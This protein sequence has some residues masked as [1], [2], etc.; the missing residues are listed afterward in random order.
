MNRELVKRII[1]SIIIL[2]LAFYFLIAGSFFSIFFIIICFIVSCYEWNK[3]NKNYFNKILGFIF[4][5]FAFHAFYFLSFNLSLLI[6]VILICIST[7]IGGYIFGKIFKGAKIT[8][9]SPN[10]TY[11]GMIGG[12]FLSLI[13]LSIFTNY[14]YYQGTYF[15]FLLLTLLL[16]TVS[17]AGDIIVSYFK[18]KAGIKNTSSLIPGHGGLLDRIDGMI[19]AIPTLYIIEII[20]S[21]NT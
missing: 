17:Q 2:P 11:A 3:M 8:K 16:S 6:F 10:K 9:I 13:C 15:Q 21:L 20:G 4:L 19:F 1:S 14:V 5:L 7:D 12:Y 18:R